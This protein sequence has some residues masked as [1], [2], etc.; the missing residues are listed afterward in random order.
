M[1]EAAVSGEQ[2]APEAIPPTCGECGYRLQGLP[3]EGTCPVCGTAY[4]ADR[5]VIAGW[6]SDVKESVSNA[7]PDRLRSVLL[8]SVLVFLIIAVDRLI[9]RRPDEAII[10]LCWA[11]FIGGIGLFN[12]RRLHETAEA[13]CHAK[14]FP[15]GFGQRNGFGKCALN[16]WSTVDKL[17]LE[18]V[19]KGR[20][21][22]QITSCTVLGVPVSI[23]FECTSE[24]AA[25]L[26][27]VITRFR[28][29]PR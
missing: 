10:W 29:A 25:W 14:L 18:P 4:Q 8:S 28:T 17:T 21:R 9:K 5:V 26:R 15:E 11:L 12:R 19:P 27:E 13:P 2:S 20:H 22:L 1:E 16:P 3:V 24:Q 23:E 6:G 7:A